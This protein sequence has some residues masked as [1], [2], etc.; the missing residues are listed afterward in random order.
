MPN[1]VR[2]SRSS[3]QVKRAE[4]PFILKGFNCSNRH[5]MKFIVPANWPQV[6]DRLL[7]EIALVNRPF[8]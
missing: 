2:F 7:V 3:D 6:K 5:D 4:W 1:F 8:D